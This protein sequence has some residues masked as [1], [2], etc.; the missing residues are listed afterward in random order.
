MLDFPI[1]LHAVSVIICI[2]IGPDV[3]PAACGA[4]VAIQVSLLHRERHA[5]ADQQRARGQSVIA[6]S[7]ADQLRIVEQ[8]VRSNRRKLVAAKRGVI[9]FSKYNSSPTF[10]MMELRTLEAPKSAVI[11]S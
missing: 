6:E 9:R 8:G 5:C 3:K 11:G 7:R 4:T 10:Q 1:V 2:L